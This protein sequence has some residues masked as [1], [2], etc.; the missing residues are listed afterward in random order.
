MNDPTPDALEPREA[1]LAAAGG[2]FGASI[3]SAGYL[4]KWL[5]LGVTIGVIAGLGAVVFYLALKYTGEFLLG[6][7]ADYHIPTPLGEGGSRGSSGFARPWAIPLVTTGGALLSAFI[8]AR[9]APEATGHGTDEA[10]EAVHTDPRAIRGRAVLVKMVAS[11]L[12]IGSG[13]SGGREGPTAQISA[14]FCSL[15]TRRLGLSD[16][17]G[18]IAVAL[19]I[20]AGIGAI[21]AAPLGGAV[22]AASITYR[23]DFDYRSLLPGFITSGTAYA[24]LGAFLGFDPL[25]GYIDAEYRFERAWPLLWFVVIG[26]VAAAV[27]YLYARIFHASV[28]LTR[29]LP[30]GSVIKP[31]VG[32]LLVG[33]LGL[34][35]PQILSSGYGW[36]QLAAD[37]GSLMSIPLWIIVVLPIAKIIATSLSIGTGGSGGLFGPG[38][39]IGAFVGAAVWR[40][41]ELSGIPGVP[42]A[43]G[44]FVVVGMMACFGSV[45][46]AP[47]AIMIMVA[48]M[49]GSFSV[50][51]GAIL[52]VGI[53]ALLMSR[54]NVTIYEAQRL[55]REAAEAERAE[56]ARKAPPG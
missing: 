43:P 22:L 29:R 32:G 44:I 26:L 8:V 56:R 47:L 14:G 3:R 30:G 27:G 15:L 35:I 38:I 24:V 10:I 12:T 28:A 39:V 25:F 52:A 5:L 51:P 19:G 40:L 9:F 37:R 23:D 48:E 4:R 7:L 53:A 20:G 49:T 13:G 55:N 46:R 34:L 11:A 6:Y 1:P 2:R 41:G 16:E 36:A 50:V 18:R 17:D 42:D 31:T 54:T 21:F 33:L 45:A